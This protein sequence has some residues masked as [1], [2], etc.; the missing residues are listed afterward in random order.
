M[1]DPA[2]PA[3]GKLPPTLRAIARLAG[4]SHVT[5]SLAL[6]N[7]PRISAA[8]RARVIA[9]A[10]RAGYQPDPHVAELMGRLR[11]GRGGAS[12]PTIA[13][14][15][16]SLTSADMQW[17]PT[18]ARFL[19]GAEVRAAQLGYTLE[20]FLVGAGGLTPARLTAVL[21]ARNIR[22]VLVSPLAQDGG[23]LALDWPRLAAVAFSYSLAQPQLHRV[24]CHHAHTM[25]V[26]LRELTQRGYRRCGVYLREGTDARVGHAWLAMYYHHWHVA[27]PG[28]APPPPLF[29]ARWSE[30]EFSRWFRRH[31]FDAVLTV[32]PPVLTWLRDLGLRVPRD[33]GFVNLDWS[34]GAG[35]PAGIDQRSELVGAAAIE[36]VAAQLSQHEYGLP[37]AP[38][39]VMIESQWREGA[40]VRARPGA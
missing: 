25:A 22:G 6:R 23:T 15:S 37:A 5:V 29:V 32:H 17:T 40:T 12:A 34:P 1:A 4:V 28:S 38:K 11:L 31:G 27:H 35:D 24:G 39:M 18:V 14:L 3:R 13:Y 16:F 8:T 20:R 19:A 9:V 2:K 33:A 30:A 7:S 36:L 10:R 21:R 26:A